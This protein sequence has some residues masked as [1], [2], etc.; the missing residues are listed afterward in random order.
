MGRG[1]EAIDI[2]G[3]RFGHLT[4]IERAGTNEE[5]KATWKCA[6]DCG[7]ECIV[8]GKYLRNGKKKTCGCRK[9]IQPKG[10]KTKSKEDRIKSIWRGMYTRC[11]N[12]SHMSYKNYGARGIK[13]CDEWIGKNGC[14]HFYEWSMENGYGDSLTI[15]RIN[16]D[17][18]YSPDNCRWADYTEQNNNRRSC[19]SLMYNGKEVTIK[20]LSKIIRVSTAVIYNVHKKEGRVDFTDWESKH[21][22]GQ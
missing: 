12:E 16:T 10:S 9:F 22:R 4:V 1:K 17:G 5:R 11:Y 21:K 15:D 20:K 18:N 19:I 8:V 2:T 13:M 3:Q 14:Q 6:C 7:N